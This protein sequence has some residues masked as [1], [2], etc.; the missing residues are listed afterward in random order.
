MTRENRR[1]VEGCKLPSYAPPTQSAL[2]WISMLK[3]IVD[4]SGQVPTLVPIQALRE[5]Q[6]DQLKT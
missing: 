5:A 2:A 6:T 4:D 1:V 3:A